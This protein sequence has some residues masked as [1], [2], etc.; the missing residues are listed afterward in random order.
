MKILFCVNC[1]VSAE[2]GATKVVLGLSRELE[3][4]GWECTVHGPQEIIGRPHPLGYE[5]FCQAMGEHLRRES[6]NYDVVDYHHQYLPFERD[7]FAPGTL[8]VARSVLLDHHFRKSTV[9]LSNSF[10]SRVARLIKRKKTARDRAVMNQLTDITIQQA[11]LINVSNRQDVQILVE[12]GVAAE[13]IVKLPYGLDEAARAE[14]EAL[15]LHPIPAQPCIVF[16]G[17]FDYRKG[18]LDIPHIF[19]SVKRAIPGA[20]LKLLGTAGLFQTAG[21]VLRFFPRHLQDSIEIR[22][23]YDATSLP[24]LIDG[25]SVGIFPSYVEG[26]PFGVL[27]MLAAGIPVFAYDAPGAPEMLPSQW[28]APPG[29]WRKIAE[30]I[31]KILKNNRDLETLRV[32]AGSRSQPFGW[33][34]I[35]ADT[36]RIY[37]EYIETRTKRGVAFSPRAATLD[38]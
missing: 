12:N 37:R 10:R 25:S 15:R 8:M 2:L 17:S 14:F 18:A 32:E 9:P 33:A 1:P 16:V 38:R 24:G 28:L 22:P 27:E 11:D 5:S 23:R 19:A 20:R 30:N 3:A 7:E 26:F 34:K 35:A 36:D 29:E 31:I 4:L 13:K 21:E 6:R